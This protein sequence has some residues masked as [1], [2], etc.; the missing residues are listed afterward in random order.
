MSSLSIHHPPEGSP[1]GGAAAGLTVED[2]ARRYRVSPDKV[3]AWI[4][5]G[6]LRA[7]NTAASL[8]GKPRWV[9]LLEALTEFEKRRAG[10]PTPKPQL[11]RRR[12]SQE[13][14]YYPDH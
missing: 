10:G 11:R 13:T 7:V 4:G 2:V 1:R 6:E 14:D 12:K 9:V 5:R 8:S 3:R